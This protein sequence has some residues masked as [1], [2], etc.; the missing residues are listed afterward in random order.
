MRIA[1]VH[2]NDGSDVRIG[3]M[4][5][6]L[7]RMGHD[8]HFIG[9]DRRP[10]T[11]KEVDLGRATPHIIVHKTRFGRA[12]VA[13][14]FHFFGH[15]ARTLAKLRPQTVQC[16]NE[17]VALLVLPFRD[18][19]YQRLVCDVFDSLVERHS[20][21]ALPVVWVLRIVSELVRSGADR[22]IA[23]DAARFER[24]GR[25]R[26]KCVIV[27]NVPEDPGGE[28]SRGFPSGAAK[29]Y[30]AGTLHEN[31]GLRQIIEVAQRVENLEIVSAGWLYDDYASHVFAGHPKVSFKGIVTA[32]QSLRLAA[33]CDAV[34]AFY[35]PTSVNNLYASPNKIYDAMSVGRPVIINSEIRVAQWVLNNKVGW[36]CRYDDIE[37]LEEIVLGL[38]SARV[39]LSA[40]AARLRELFV[41]GHTWERMEG[42]LAS[43][44]AA[45]ARVPG[46]VAP[47][48]G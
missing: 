31:R 42:R 43:L 21:R 30:V 47:R 48:T 36:A 15:I 5:R 38:Q 45:L 4:C 2:G 44:Y 33:Q 29:I 17:D 41:N 28:L 37:G 19:F 10:D 40:W 11:E 14:Q 23:T 8:V 35:A 39:S 18:L 16:V 9:W 34:L 7:S 27:E 46:H 22:L 24:F 32:R 13:G 1:I 25:Y 12:S 6:S 20:D 3:K 26:G